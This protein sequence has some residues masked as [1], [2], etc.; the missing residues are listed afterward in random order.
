MA[1]RRCAGCARSSTA[2]ARRAAGHARGIREARAAAAGRRRSRRSNAP[3]KTCALSSKRSCPP[4]LSLDTMPGVRCERI[5]RPIDAWACTCPPARRRCPPPRS[6]WRCRR[7]SP[8]ATRVRTPARPDAD[9]NSRGRARRRA[10]CAAWTPCSRWAARRP[11][12]R[13]PSA[14]IPFRKVDK[15]FG[16]GNAWV[17][18]AKQLVAADPAGAAIDLPAGPSEVLVIADES[19]NADSSPRT[20]WRRP[21]TTPLRRSILVTTSAALAQ[22]CAAKSTAQAR[23]SRAGATSSSQSMSE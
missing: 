4:P 11:S 15:I 20:C 13:W 23:C 7:A 17:T 16:P 9:G 18:A 21:N 3:L 19:A 12:L 2:L 6:C 8:A 1:T 10:S 5:T 14:R 22:R